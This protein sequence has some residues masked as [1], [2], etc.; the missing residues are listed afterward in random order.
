MPAAWRR[1]T[2]VPRPAGRTR[3]D[4]A[5]RSGFAV[6]ARVAP[7]ATRRAS[8]RAAVAVRAAVSAEPAAAEATKVWQIT[9]DA[10]K[11]SYGPLPTLR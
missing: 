1:L 9:Y 4:S 3:A 2:R 10:S 8:Q 6:G 7:T 5:A 11:V